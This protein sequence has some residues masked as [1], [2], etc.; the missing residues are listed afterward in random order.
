MMGEWI[1]I[2]QW[3]QCREMARPGI[4]FEIRNGDGNSMFTPC[5]VPL[6]PA[7]FDWKSPP[8][9]F[10]AVREDDTNPGRSAPLPKPGE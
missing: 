5:V 7:P 2:A 6:P 10:R 9:E 4:V 1:A 8:V 3:E